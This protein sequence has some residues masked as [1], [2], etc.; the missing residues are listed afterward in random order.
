MQR[1]DKL[2]QHATDVRK[3]RGLHFTMGFV[4]PECNGRWLAKSRLWNGVTGGKRKEFISYHNT[5][6]EAI[7]EVSRMAE[8]YADPNNM[9]KT[10]IIVDNIGR[11]E[12]DDQTNDIQNNNSYGH[13][14]HSL[15]CD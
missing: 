7:Q 11:G 14:P 1:I 13:T 10:P 2:I 4:S 12:V 8:Q 15:T 5:Q 6:E 9:R 3:K